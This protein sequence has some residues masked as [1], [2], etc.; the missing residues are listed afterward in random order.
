[1]YQRIQW[2]V[3]IS[4]SLTL[5]AA[6]AVVAPELAPEL[7]RDETGQHRILTRR[8]RQ[9]RGTLNIFNGKISNEYPAGD[10][11]K[12]YAT[13]T[14]KSHRGKAYKSKCKSFKSAKSF[15]VGK[16]GKSGK[17]G[18]S[19]LDCQ[20]VTQTPVLAP[21][22]S[23]VVAPTR[24][25]TIT[26]S[27]SLA[28]LSQAGRENDISSIVN[29]LLITVTPG[30]AEA[31]A[32]AWMTYVDTINSCLDGGAA[33]MDRFILSLFYYRTGGGRWVSNDAWLT[34]SD[35]CN[36]FGIRCDS[37]GN[38]QKIQMNENNVVGEIPAEFSRLQD[39][40]TLLFYNNFLMGEIPTALYSL[41]NLIYIDVEANNLSGKLS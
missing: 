6:A 10:L 41:P 22:R 36:W 8:N 3:L 21:T 25:P 9:L 29:D 32:I 37:N 5:S 14:V 19:S 26:D 16:N 18:K 12:K 11:V 23:P 35:H 39:L 4:V 40:S 30:S 1:M 27:P 34:T 33:M 28:C 7:V 15:K 24:Q 38:I 31:A 13:K 20:Q 2:I 17:S